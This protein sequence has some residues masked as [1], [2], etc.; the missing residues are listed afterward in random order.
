L[1]GQGNF[2]H[3]LLS[4]KIKKIKKREK[5]KKYT[6]ILKEG[7]RKVSWGVT[8]GLKDWASLDQHTWLPLCENGR[9]KTVKDAVK[10]NN[11]NNNNK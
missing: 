11:N 4:E 5:M 6:W 8:V 9:R 1:F 3:I 7:R 2:S 10:I